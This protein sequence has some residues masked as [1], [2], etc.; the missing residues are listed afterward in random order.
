M[1]Y[2]A[3]EQSSLTDYINSLDTGY[4]TSVGELGSKLSGGQRQR[5]A[6]ARAFVKNS[7]L[8]ILDEPTSALDAQTE[9]EIQKSLDNLMKNRAT[10]IIAH[11]LST[12]KNVDRILVLNNGKIVEEGNHESLLNKKG[13]Y[14]KLYQQQCGKVEELKN[15]A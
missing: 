4:Q 8:L 11:R 7:D 14:Y 3:A 6:I 2:Q 5:V 1:V 10:L 13:L 9:Q 15:G 12:I